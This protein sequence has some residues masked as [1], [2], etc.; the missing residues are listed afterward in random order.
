MQLEGKRIVV[1][2]G[3]GS[4]GQTVVRRLLRG[5]MGRPVVGGCIGGTEDAI[6]D[7]VTGLPD[8]GN[9]VQEVAEAVVRLL[10]DPDYADQLGQQGRQQ[11]LREFDSSIQQQRFAELVKEFMSASSPGSSSQNGAQA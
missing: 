11:V 2:G 1:T 5:E 8:D 10:D 9:P 7:G 3:T 6:V 4:L